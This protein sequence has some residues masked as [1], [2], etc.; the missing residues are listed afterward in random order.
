M[1]L[2]VVI[3][4]AGLPARAQYAGGTGTAEDPYRIETAGQLNTIGLYPEDWDKHFRLVADVDMND[5]TGAKVNLIPRFE[6]VF[7]GNDHTIANLTY[8]VKDEDNLGECRTY[9]VLGCSVCLAERM[10]W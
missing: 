6:G 7:D 3:L 2:S 8:L 1:F 5:L 4:A 10:P 9:G